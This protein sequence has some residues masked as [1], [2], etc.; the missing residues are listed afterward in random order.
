MLLFDVEQC[1]GTLP[2]NMASA[3]G[4]SDIFLRGNNLSGMNEHPLKNVAL[5]LLS[6]WHA[7]DVL[8]G[9]PHWRRYS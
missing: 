3:E 1:A 9:R 5:G 6:T 4:L 2:R 7:V 8:D